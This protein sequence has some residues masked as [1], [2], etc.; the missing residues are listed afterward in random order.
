[1]FPSSSSSAAPGP[2]GGPAAYVDATSSPDLGFIV[3]PG[4]L[5]TRT[6]EDVPLASAFFTAPREV[7]GPSIARAAL[8]AGLLDAERRALHRRGQGKDAE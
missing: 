2:Y 3:P 5:P 4:V 7:V 1:M 6:V 8:N